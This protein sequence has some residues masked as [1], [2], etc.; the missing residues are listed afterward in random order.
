MIKL[1]IPREIIQEIRKKDIELYSG[2]A[3]FTRYYAYISSAPFSKTVVAVKSNPKTNKLIAKKVIYIDG[4]TEKRWVRDINFGYV[5]GYQVCWSDEL[6]GRKS[7]DSWREVNWKCGVNAVYVG[8]SQVNDEY[9]YAALEECTEQGVDLFE[10]LKIWREHQKV[11]F[12]ARMGLGL[13]AIQKSIVAR[14][15]KSRDFV[16][17]LRNKAEFIKFYKP[18]A[19]VLIKAYL[20]GNSI[21]TCQEVDNFFGS[22]PQRDIKAKIPYGERKH[23]MQYL[24]ENK[25]SR[26]L[27]TDYIKACIALKLNLSD[28]KNTRPKDFMYWHD[29]RIAEKDAIEMTKRA[30]EAEKLKDKFSDATKRYMELQCQIRGFSI[31]LARTPAELTAEGEFLHHCVGSNLY[32]LKVINGESLIFFVRKEEKT[33]FVTVEY[34][35]TE[36]TVVQSYG[37]HNSRPTKEVIDCLTEWQIYANEKVKSLKKAA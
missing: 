12:L 24:C 20:T 31:I 17:W 37:D 16:H 25:I 6:R 18:N 11:E 28:T 27:Y 2:V 7:Q 30:E 4:I 23:V 10:Y 35:L 22:S 1:G 33:P 13:Y 3:N 34:S 36:K 15:E 26:I 21:E 5:C 9:R 19:K 8:V 29:A 14:C 32:T